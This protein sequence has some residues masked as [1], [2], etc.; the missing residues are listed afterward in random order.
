VYI[1]GAVAQ[2]G[3]YPIPPGT[4]LL[5][6]IVLAGGETARADLRK[7]SVLR[8][9]QTYIVDLEA[10]RH[11]GYQG[12]YKLLSNDYVFVPEKS[13]FT[14]ETLALVMSGVTAALGLFNLF[15]ALK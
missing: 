6:S 1:L 5:A 9:N 15:V 4:P 13:G 8:E 11:G 3:L 7:T 12:R 2:P 14:R 10:A